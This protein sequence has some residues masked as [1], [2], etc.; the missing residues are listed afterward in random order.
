MT[1]RDNHCVGTTPN[2]RL[3]NITVTG[4]GTG[5][6][7]TVTN[8]TTPLAYQVAYRQRNNQSW[9]VLTAGSSSGPYQGWRLDRCNQGRTRQQVR[10][11]FFA[12]DLIA[13]TAG[14]YSGKLYLLVAPQ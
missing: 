8:G 11:R 13:A 5:G 2:N 6:A 10:V 4:S 9:T 14:A 7:F 12:A 1:G 3:Y